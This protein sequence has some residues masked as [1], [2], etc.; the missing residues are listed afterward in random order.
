[1]ILLKI[2]A[3]IDLSFGITKYFR[4]YSVFIYF[5][6]KKNALDITSQASPFLKKLP[7]YGLNISDCYQ[8]K[9]IT[10]SL[11]DDVDTPSL[12]FMF[13]DGVGFSLEEHCQSTAGI[14]LAHFCH[15]VTLV[16]DGEP[17][18]VEDIQID[19][20]VIIE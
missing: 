14:S 6:N 11:R 2:G 20:L 3:K 15:F 16:A 10:V 4:G 13:D 19:A 5:Q 1:M 9:L 12:V 18:A 8:K 7:L 17:C